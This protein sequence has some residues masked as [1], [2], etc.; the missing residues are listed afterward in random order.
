MRQEI[1]EHK[2]EVEFR[3]NLLDEQ[4][5]DL[6]FKQEHTEKLVQINTSSREELEQGFQSVRDLTKNSIDALNNEFLLFKSNLDV[7]FVRVC[8]TAKK[9]S[10]RIKDLEIQ[11]KTFYKNQK[12]FED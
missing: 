6:I 10:D 1:V 2:V 9:D 11:Q 8:D 5:K 3:H 4:L 12:T 7:E